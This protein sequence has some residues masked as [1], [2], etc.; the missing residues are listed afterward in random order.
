[1]S[2]FTLVSIPEADLGL[3]PDGDPALGALTYW[4]VDDVTLAVEAALGAGASE[5]GP[6]MDVGDGIITA[7]VETPDGSIVGFIF[8][9][10]F[11]AT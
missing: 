6:P 10:H 5:H 11:K 1:M 8:N 4:G 3:I 9:P 2:R 7:T